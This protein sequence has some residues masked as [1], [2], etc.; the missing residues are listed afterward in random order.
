MDNHTSNNPSWITA[1]PNGA[2]LG[3]EMQH[4]WSRHL[5]EGRKTIEV[6]NYEL[7]P[8]LM[9]RKLYIIESPPGKDG[10]SALGDRIEF[11][12]NREGGGGGPRIVGWCRFDSIQTYTCQEDF[13]AD[14]DR[15]LVSPNSGYAW[16][17]GITAM[18]Y[19]WVVQECHCFFP[20]ADDKHSTNDNG[21]PMDTK[22]ATQF[23]LAERRKRSL[24]ELLTTV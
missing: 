15:H 13:E 23:R 19:G 9:G 24:F 1:L 14:E 11:A 17:A 16:Q 21:S 6:R 10:V 5:L 2:T 22:E 12:H 3:L 7:P 4:P 8:A 20:T 18:L